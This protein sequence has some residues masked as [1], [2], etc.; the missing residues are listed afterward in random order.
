[1]SPADYPREELRH[2]HRLHVL[3]EEI[4]LWLAVLG[5]LLFLTLGIWFGATIQ[6]VNHPPADAVS[7]LDRIID[8]AAIE[9][10]YA[11]SCAD[12]CT[13]AKLEVR[14]YNTADHTCVCK[15]NSP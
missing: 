5:V 6:R 2:H 15:E 13:A 4:P 12:I 14:R 8:A 7:E 3:T 1:M 10:A 9:E 11:K